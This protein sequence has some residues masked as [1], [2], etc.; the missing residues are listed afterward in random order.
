MRDHH[1]LSPYNCRSIQWSFSC[2]QCTVKAVMWSATAGLNHRRP[3]KTKRGL[4]SDPR[5]LGQPLQPSLA[6]RES[7]V[8]RN[9]QLFRSSIQWC[10]WNV[11]ILERIHNTLFILVCSLRFS[12]LFEVLW[13]QHQTLICTKEE[14]ADL[15]ENICLDLV[16]T[17]SNLNWLTCETIWTWAVQNQDESGA[18]RPCD[19]PN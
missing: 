11:I 15:T 5:P 12:G 16:K 10:Y 9:R 4:C 6:Q 7:S 13:R 3:L 14:K 19:Y 2:P 18:A 1:V 8:N 17:S